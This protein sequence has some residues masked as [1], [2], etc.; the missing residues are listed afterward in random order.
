MKYI[1]LAA[2]ICL[3][4]IFIKAGIGKI[5]GF[6]STAEMMTNKG[7]PIAEIL[8]IFTIAF[9]LFGGFFFAFGLQS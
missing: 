5:M 4:S 3:C 7:L 6:A 8:L 1:P 9:Q 2:R